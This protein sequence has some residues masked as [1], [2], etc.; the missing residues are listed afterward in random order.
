[1]I[2]LVLQEM[3]IGLIFLR[4]LVVLKSLQQDLMVIT[5]NFLSLLEAVVV[6]MNHLLVVV[7]EVAVVLVV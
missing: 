2:G 3:F 5:Y 4:L 1:M 6:V 7:G